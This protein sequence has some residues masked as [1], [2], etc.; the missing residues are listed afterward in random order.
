[1]GEKAIA[2]VQ[3][4]FLALIRSLVDA[5]D[6]VWLEADSSGSDIVFLVSVSKPDLGKVIGK[7]GRTARA[8]RALLIAAGMKH[9]RRFELRID[10]RTDGPALRAQ[11]ESGR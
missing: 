3:D 2:D 11:R 10:T 5:P 9:G 4:V 6:A 8:L 7:Q 1:M